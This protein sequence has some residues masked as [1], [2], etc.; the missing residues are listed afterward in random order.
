MAKVYYVFKMWQG[1]RNGCASQI[2]SRAQNQLM[3]AVGYSSDTEE[4]YKASWS[5]F[6][7]DG[8]AA[9]KLSERSPLPPA[10]CGKVLHGGQTQILNVS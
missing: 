7:Y 1:S 10:L 3:T 9:F 6:Q 4:I 8:L 5:L 2:E